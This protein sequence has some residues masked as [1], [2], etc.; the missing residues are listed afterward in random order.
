MP[1]ILAD[2]YY[3]RY[4][5]VNRDYPSASK[6]C[7][8][9]RKISLLED[10]IERALP[11]DKKQAFRDLMHLHQDLIFVSSED[12]FL[13]GFRLGTQLMVAALGEEC[14]SMDS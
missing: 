12:D 7:A 2:L 1:S 14:V 9:S 11:D 3:G 4:T 6:Y 13:E 5:A 8:L 10:E